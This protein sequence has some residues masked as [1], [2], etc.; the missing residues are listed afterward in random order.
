MNN[1]MDNNSS[2]YNTGLEN[3]DIKKIVTY[4][5]LMLMLVF[6]PLTIGISEFNKTKDL[7][8]LKTIEGVVEE[9]DIETGSFQNNKLYIVIENDPNLENDDKQNSE[10][11]DTEQTREYS[12][13]ANGKWTINLS[14]VKEK[15]LKGDT[16]TINYLEKDLE[17]VS[18]KANGIEILTE[19]EYLKLYDKLHNFNGY[20]LEIFTVMALA[21]S[22]SLITKRNKEDK[23]SEK[24]KF[25]KKVLGFSSL[26]I[27]VGLI[28]LGIN[29]LN[30]ELLNFEKNILLTIGFIISNILLFILGFYFI[31]PSNYNNDTKGL[32]SE[33]KT[34]KFQI[35]F[36]LIIGIM[37]MITF[38]LILVYGKMKI[39]FGSIIISIVIGILIISYLISSISKLN[40][41]NK[42]YKLIKNNNYKPNSVYEKLLNDYLNESLIENLKYKI[43]YNLDYG[44][45]LKD[46]IIKLVIILPKEIFNLEDNVQAVYKITV[47][48]ISL[49]IRNNNLI[50]KLQIKY[51]YLLD[52]EQESNDNKDEANKD[53]SEIKPFEELINLKNQTIKYDINNPLKVYEELLNHLTNVKN[54]IIEYLNI[55]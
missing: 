32:L 19:E 45:N 14:D 29:L 33:E 36:K 40:K 31:I 7:T 43:E 15:I 35:I 51:K 25:I 42:M 8:N 3:I 11:V 44:F 13:Y 2:K 41:I 9:I 20:L 52:K 50:R 17:I 6:V 53:K 55:E 30:K 48:N 27:S 34:S 4:L 38:V 47:N 26:L 39:N 49:L 12:L 1:N 46:D 16:V 18:L 22:I 10:D 23:D 24:K 21:V 37:L 28:L 54:Q 5:L